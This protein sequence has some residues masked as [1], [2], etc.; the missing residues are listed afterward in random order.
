MVILDA[1]SGTEIAVYYRTPTTQ[2]RTAWLASQ[3]EREGT[4]VK[5]KSVET[6]VHWGAEIMTGVS[7]GC[8]G[9]PGE[10]GDVKP[11]SSNADSPEY[12][13]DWKQLLCEFAP[14]FVEF[15]ARR[16]FEGNR[17]LFKP[18]PAKTVYDSKN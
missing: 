18:A 15:F 10:N 2:E 4:E 14:E 11:I 16:V 7:D 6:N 3:F 8:F 12:R 17:Q 5:D 13:A 1:I 9:I